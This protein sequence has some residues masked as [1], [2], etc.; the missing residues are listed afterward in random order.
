MYGTRFCPYCVGARRF[1]DSRGIAYRDIRVDEAPQLRE[2]MRQRGGGRTV[3]QIWIG[4]EHV[5]GFTDLLALDADGRLQQL[6]E[7]S[8]A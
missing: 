2:E 3:P 8:Q 7:E 6:L 5:G 1:F 4:S